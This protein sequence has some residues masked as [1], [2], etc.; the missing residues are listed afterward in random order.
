MLNGNNGGEAYIDTAAYAMLA[1]AI[2]A[3]INIEFFIVRC[4]FIF[5]FYL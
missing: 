5:F 1:T 3:I 2:I 4:F